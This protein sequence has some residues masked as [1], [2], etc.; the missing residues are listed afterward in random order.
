MP[1]GYR[2]P[3]RPFDPP[4]DSDYHRAVREGRPANR[5][6]DHFAPSKVGAIAAAADGGGG[7]AKAPYLNGAVAG[8]GGGGN[9]S[10]RKAA[11]GHSHEGAG[12]SD[13]G[14][15]GDAIYDHIII[16]S[17]MSALY[18]AALLSLCGHRCLVLERRHVIGGDATILDP[19]AAASNAAAAAAAATAATN[20]AAARDADL[21]A[22]AAARPL[23][24]FDT[25]YPVIGRPRIAD[26]ISVACHPSAEAPEW[27]Y[28][29]AGGDGPLE[30]SIYASV[31]SGTREELLFP[32]G[33]ATLS[34]TMACAAPEHRRSLYAIIAQVADAFKDAAPFFMQRTVTASAAATMAAL[35]VRPFAAAV[36]SCGDAFKAIQDGP[37]LSLLSTL[38]TAENIPFQ[39]VAFGAY[40]LHAAQRFDGQFVTQYGWEGLVAAILPTI[41]A[42]GGRVLTAAPVAHVVAEGGRAIGVKMEKEA[43]GAVIWVRPGGSIISAIGVLE[44]FNNLLTQQTFDE[45]GGWPAGFT[46]LEEVRPRVHMCVGLQGNWAER[47]AAPPYDFVHSRDPLNPP[48]QH[49]LGVSS[50][51]YR[52]SFT[53]SKARCA[54]AVAAHDVAASAAPL[55]P[56]SLLPPCRR[57][58][59]CGVVIS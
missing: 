35:G 20:A 12:P 8:R 28:I 50:E 13:G 10:G 51:W 36:I 5:L 33:T 47:F 3:A 39:S 46:E 55:S 37:L 4:A 24:Q 9:G 19:E 21:A 31:E 23:W 54:F 40:V 53:V 26:L 22:A 42:A 45:I 27:N 56:R 43:G 34:A 15:R 18:A 57:R 41:E 38:F 29:A 25:R 16:G 44:T 59:E 17:D 49:D 11:A 14:G 58:L 30:T 1:R 6:F 7:G 32:A 52:I 48:E 2:L